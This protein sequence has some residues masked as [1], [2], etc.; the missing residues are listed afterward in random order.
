MQMLVLLYLFL[1]TCEGRSVASDNNLFLTDLTPKK[2]SASLTLKELADY[3]F[4]KFPLQV[5]ILEGY[6]SSHVP[7][8]TL[9]TA[10]IYNIHLLK[11]QEGVVAKDSL[12]HRY[13]IP[14]NTA[15]H[16]GLLPSKEALQAYYGKSNQGSS[17][18]LSFPKVSD[19]LAMKVLP[20]VV[21]AT[22][23]SKIEGGKGN[24]EAGEVFAIGKVS[25]LKKKKVRIDVHSKAMWYLH[26]F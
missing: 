9:S 22:K 7:H 6:M 26:Y 24:V 12:G 17:T 3:H 8:L 1:N 18:D 15:I 4:P 2:T 10:D 20:K 14:L 21:C 16:F 5:Q 19:I 11:R 25:K 23:A 13:N